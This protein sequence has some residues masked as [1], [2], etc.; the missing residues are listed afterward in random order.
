MAIY[1]FE[2]NVPEL[3]GD[4]SAW[5]AENATVLGKVRLGEQSSIWFNAVLRGDNELIDIGARTNVQDGCV[6]HT[7]MGYPLTVGEGCTIGHMAMLHGCTIGNNTL[8]GMGATVM[9]GAV[10]GNNCVV[11]AHALI[12]EG[13]EI[14]DNSLVV[15]MPG[16]VIRTTGEPGL[17]ML[18]E[19]ADIYVGKAERYAK[20]FRR[21]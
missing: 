10:I 21:V 18:R 6:F 4:G 11:G 9:N 15:G 3:T 8:V 17:K 13:R 2:G 12:P 5:V 1:E 7:D 14:P 20:S 19:A 16:K